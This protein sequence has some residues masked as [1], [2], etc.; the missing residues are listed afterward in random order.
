MSRSAHVLEA[1]SCVL[2][3]FS[4]ADV[5][6]AVVSCLH[7]S[8]LATDA[9]AITSRKLSELLANCIRMNVDCPSSQLEQVS[10]SEVLHRALISGI[11]ERKEG[12]DANPVAPCTEIPSL[13][14]IFFLVKKVHLATVYI[15]FS[16]DN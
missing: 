13:P 12:N 3:L 4:C 9:T 10:V 1:W 14:A 11:G 8:T 5:R 16:I 6:I 2:L 7:I 15:L